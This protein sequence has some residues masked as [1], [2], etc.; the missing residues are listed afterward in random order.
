MA[1]PARTMIDCRGM[2]C[3]TPIL[4]I[5]TAARKA[6]GAPAILEVLVDDDAFPRDVEAWC[7]TSKSTLIALDDEGDGLMRARIGLNGG[8]ESPVPSLEQLEPSAND[9][10]QPVARSFPTVEL[11][12]C[13]LRCPAPI[14]RI[15][16]ATQAFES[17]PGYLRVM[18][19]DPEFPPDL[20]A[21][22]KTSGAAI[23]EIES[24]TGK[25]IVTLALNGAPCA[26][27]SAEVGAAGRSLST[28][29]AVKPADS[30][31]LVPAPHEEAARVLDL[32]GLR[33]PDPILKLSSL[34]AQRPVGDWVVVADDPAFVV[35]VV[36]WAGATHAA[37]KRVEQ[38]GGAT[39]IEMRFGQSDSTPPR[40]LAPVAH[41]GAASY[42][43]APLTYVDG[44]ELSESMVVASEEAA[45]QRHNRCTLMVMRNDFETL[46]AAFMMATTAAA[47]G[48][49]V[50]MFYSFWGVNVLRADSARRDGSRSKATFLQ[51][52]MKWMMPKGPQRQKLSKM[53]MAGMGTGMMQYFMSKSNV[54]SLQQLMDTAVEQR[55]RFVVCAMSMGIM[56]IEKRD[57]MDL[58]NL[59]FAGMASF[60][61]QSQGS[62]STFVF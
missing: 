58:P 5:A 59:E 22:C 56:G 25:T 32:R 62:S 18:A 1:N 13:G 45:P 29:T 43:P 61:E 9:N 55:V 39:T 21:W 26:T 8:Q 46:M 4:H 19:D 40:A 28:P 44:G 23:S 33:A 53:H 7:R 35:D 52:M 16:K 10:A 51:R 14:L 15:S 60:V 54:M 17:R 36:A 47:Q 2:Q 34:L 37:L 11:D 30:S 41:A 24:A 12:C 38:A 27:P 42:T 49:E 50:V 3:P 57:L 48:I 31:R 6:G 20:K